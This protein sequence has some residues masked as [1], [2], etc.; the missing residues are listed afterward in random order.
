MFLKINKVDTITMKIKNSLRKDI[1]LFLRESRKKKSLSANQLGSLVHLSQQQVSRYELGITTISIEMLN[2]FLIA[3]D[4][5]WSDFFFSV[6][7]DYSDEIKELK[8]GYY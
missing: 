5:N 3:L 6:M 1:G 7:A 4:K 2:V 8:T